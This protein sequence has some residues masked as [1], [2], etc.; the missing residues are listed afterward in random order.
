MLITPKILKQQAL[1]IWQRGDIHRAWLQN[2][3]YF[4]LDIPLK[5]ISAKNLLTNYS[6]LQDAI[7][8]LRLD[9]QKQGYLIIDKAITHRQL[10]E[11]KLPAC[12]TFKN[13]I[14]FLNYLSKAAEFKQ[15]QLLCSQSLQQDSLLLDWLIHYPFKLMQ[16]D[17]VWSQ[18]LKVCHYFKAHPRPDC[19]IRQLDIKGIDSK[20][21]EKHKSVLNELL[22]QTLVK[23]D[24]NENITGL[25]HHGFERRYGLRYDQPSIRFRILDTSLNICGLADLTLTLDEFKQ[26]DISAQTIF[27]VENKVTMLAFPNFP[28]AIVIF[29]LGYAV[30]LLADAKCMQGKALYYWGDL[31]TD[32]MAILSRLRQYYPLV[33]SLLMDLETLEK[34]CGF[35]EKMPINDTEKS[36][37][38]LTDAEQYL[39]RKLQLESLRLEQERISFSCLQLALEKLLADLKL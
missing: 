17:N 8:I 36:L 3:T 11:Q 10:G 29:G 22:T 20:F 4:P 28:K 30:N 38:F 14:V 35:V 37:Q 15:F 5:N 32:G 23:S 24:Y 33:K 25:S 27:I 16:Y 2:T 19:Y 12:I 21:I 7:Y 34:F 26:L 9:S 31:D 13:E 1:K 39:Y 18:L 6:E